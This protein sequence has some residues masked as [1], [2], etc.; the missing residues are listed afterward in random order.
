MDKDKIETKYIKDVKNFFIEESKKFLTSEVCGFFG[1]DNDKKTYIAKIE[2]NQASDPINFFAISPT[3]YL[4]FKQQYL[5]L[6]IFHSHVQGDE[7][8]SEFDIKTS[9][10]TCIPF[11]IYS[12]NTNKFSFY[13]PKNKEYNTKI[14]NRIKNKI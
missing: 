10:S 5:L 7:S 4:K 14:V 13:E 9:E 3:S 2:E 11:M 6:A 12:I 1:Y 8:L